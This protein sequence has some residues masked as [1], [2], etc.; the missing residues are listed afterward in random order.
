[1][2]KFV[3]LVIMLLFS[4]QGIADDVVSTKH[5]A[6]EKLL[7]LFNMHESYDQAM[8]QTML[9]P[10][11]LIE[12]QDITEE[13]KIQAKKS[14][15]ASIKIAMENFSWEKIKSIFIDIYA[16]V[17]S[18][19]ELEGLIKFYE[20][21]VGQM[22]IRKQPQLTAATMTRMQELMLQ[23]M[24]EIQKA[25]EQAIEQSKAASKGSG[26]NTEKQTPG[27]DIP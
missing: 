13:K 6:A 2:K 19:E 22:F 27:L 4:V 24:P 11:S 12:S 1:M 21:P 10:T 7:D 18:L 3:I 20:S 5:A 25:T 14:A 17:L 16:E 26:E 23:M 15:E 8:Q 9:M